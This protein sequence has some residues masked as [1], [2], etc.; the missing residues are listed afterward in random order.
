MGEKSLIS[1][2]FVIIPSYCCSYILIF[3]SHIHF[4]YLDFVVSGSINIKIKFVMKGV[5]KDEGQKSA[6]VC[7]FI[8]I[9]P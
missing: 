5:F 3:I 1:A 7:R 4:G 9:Y 6:M 8:L 2:V